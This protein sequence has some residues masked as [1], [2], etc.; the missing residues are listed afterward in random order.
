MLKRCDLGPVA[1]KGKGTGQTYKEWKAD[2]LGIALEYRC[3]LST[4][5]RKRIEKTKHT[6][7]CFAVHG[8]AKLA[9]ASG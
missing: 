3:L 4:P 5:Y 7:V 1:R 8:Q 2:N 6:F 9:G